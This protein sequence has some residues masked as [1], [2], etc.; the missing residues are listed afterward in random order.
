MTDGRGGEANFHLA[1][2][3]RIKLDLL[4]NQR[5]AEFVTNS[6]FHYYLL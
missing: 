6:S 1:V 2:L 3:G 5:G 4:D